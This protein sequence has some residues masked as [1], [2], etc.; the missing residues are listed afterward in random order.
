MH[1]SSLS[2]SRGRF[3]CV[4]Y[5]SASLTSG[6]ASG[7]VSLWVS[8]DGGGGERERLAAAAGNRSAVRGVGQARSLPDVDGDGSGLWESPISS[9]GDGGRGL[10]ESPTSGL[11]SIPWLY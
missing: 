3:T 6:L 9:T 4:S 11:M 5:S 8:V 1:E 10:A 2:L 7:I